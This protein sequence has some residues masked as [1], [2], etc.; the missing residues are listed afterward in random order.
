MTWTS[1]TRESSVEG[2]SPHDPVGPLTLRSMWRSAA[3]ARRDD[4]PAGSA[5]SEWK[6]PPFVYYDESNDRLVVW[7]AL[8]NRPGLLT[9]DN[10]IPP[11]TGWYAA[12]DAFAPAP[13][14]LTFAA[15]N[16][17][18]LYAAPSHLGAKISGYR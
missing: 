7:T 17:Q 9:E 8:V 12:S 1:T 15:I 16:A 13:T 14:V 10:I 6:I 3:G 5:R 11:E 2:V 4:Y 18:L